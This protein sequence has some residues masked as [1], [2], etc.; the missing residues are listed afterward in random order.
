VNAWFAWADVRAG[1]IDARRTPR[2]V[3]WRGVRIGGA[4]YALGYAVRATLAR[5]Q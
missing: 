3:P 4:D 1:W 2:P 5:G